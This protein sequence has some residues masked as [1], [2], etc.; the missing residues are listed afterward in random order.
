MFYELPFDLQ[1]YIIYYCNLIFDKNSIFSFYNKNQQTKI[2]DEWYKSSKIEFFNTNNIFIK[3]INNIFH[4]VN[5][6]PCVIIYIND[7]IIK[8]WYYNGINTRLNDKPCKIIYNKKRILK[9]VWKNEDGKIHRDFNNP[10]IIYDN[11]I[12]KYYQNII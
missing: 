2:L 3:K 12:Y 11:N 5:D 4:S 10:A 7:C 6:D 9:Q 8:K 1:L